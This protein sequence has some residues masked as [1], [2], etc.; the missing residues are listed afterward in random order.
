MSENNEEQIA[1]SKEW[2][3]KFIT[4]IKTINR[5]FGAYR[6]KHFVEDYFDGNTYIPKE[7]FI[8][9]AKELGYREESHHFNMSFQKA[10]KN[11]KQSKL[12]R[13]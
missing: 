3:S 8:E 11:T 5:E 9:A 6:L 1:M 10:L 2:I 7:A 13:S 12:S 4:P